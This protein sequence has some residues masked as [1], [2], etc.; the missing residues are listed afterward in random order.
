MV[1][2]NLYGNKEHF[3]RS[4]GK[5]LFPDYIISLPLRDSDSLPFDSD[6]TCA[7]GA[8]KFP[9]YKL[10]PISI[11]HYSKVDS[12]FLNSYKIKDIYPNYIYVFK[13]KPKDLES[14]QES[15]SSNFP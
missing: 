6:L 5:K 3:I 7:F 2:S 9:L 8:I 14:I 13:G 15:Y 12:K 10:V 11:E 4:E 1:F